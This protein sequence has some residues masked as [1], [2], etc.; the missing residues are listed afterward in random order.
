MQLKGKT[1]TTRGEKAVDFFLGF[2][3]WWVLNLAGLAVQTAMGFWAISLANDRG[4]LASLLGN[5]TGLLGLLGFA[6][7]IVAIAVFAFIR[8]WISL[9]ALAGFA[10]ALLLVLCAGLAVMAVCYSAS[11]NGIFQ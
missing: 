11:G 9:G 3:G 8:H 2:A 1:Y 6:L 7:S 4:P 5:L 10:S